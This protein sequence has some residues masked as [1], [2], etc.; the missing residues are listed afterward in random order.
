MNAIVS[1]ATGSLLYNTTEKWVYQYNG[2]AWVKLIATVLNVV[3]KTS[4]Y[5][6]TLADNGSVITF[7]STSDVT[8]S[9]DSGLPIGFNVSIY[10][11][12]DGKVNFTGV[13]GVTLKNRLMRFKSAGKDAGIGLVS[14]AT[15]VF[16]ITGDLKL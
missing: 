12:G 8:L 16:H 1:P 7:N 2:S 9:I 14:T 10:Q 4:D 13:S 5:T 11:I 15:N 3:E 6:L